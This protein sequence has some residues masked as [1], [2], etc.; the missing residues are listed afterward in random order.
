MPRPH[1]P[2]AAKTRQIEQNAVDLA[3]KI[4][5]VNVTGNRGKGTVDDGKARIISSLR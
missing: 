2:V 3:T 4:A 1:Y 5:L